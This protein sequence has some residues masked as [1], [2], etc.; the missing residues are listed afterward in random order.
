MPSPTADFHLGSHTRADASAGAGFIVASA[1]AFL[2][3]STDYEP[4]AASPYPAVAH[5]A[6]DTEP[7]FVLEPSASLSFLANVDSA[8]PATASIAT[9][10]DNATSIVAER[11]RTT[12][13]TTNY[14]S[15]R[16]STSIAIRRALASTV[17]A[18]GPSTTTGSKRTFSNRAP[19]RTY[20]P[21]SCFG[22]GPVL[23]N[24]SKFFTNFARLAVIFNRIGWYL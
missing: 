22:Q 11:L 20:L 4:R 18:D 19:T 9:V 6:N 2:P 17:D 23:D 10:A 24:F 8:L 21:G 13:I 7:S 1:D 15:S 14:F 12:P 3:S 5:P 16:H